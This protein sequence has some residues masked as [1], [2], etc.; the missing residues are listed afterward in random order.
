[1]ITPLGD[2]F[3]L[4]RRYAERAGCVELAQSNG[5]AWECTR[6]EEIR[7]RDQRVKFQAMQNFHNRFDKFESWFSGFLTLMK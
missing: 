3:H 4:L 2:V 6:Q 5:L 1:M 7:K